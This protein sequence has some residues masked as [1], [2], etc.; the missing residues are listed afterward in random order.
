M[1]G[2]NEIGEMGGGIMGKEDLLEM[3]V[4]RGLE[5]CEGGDVKGVYGKGGGGEMKKLRGMCGG[6][7]GGGD[8]GVWV[9]S[10]KLWVKEC[11]E[12]VVEL[13]VGKVMKK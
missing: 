6:L 2:K 1:S 13:I 4:R 3:Y 8:G 11:V 10:W 12:E 9:E 7:E 5:E